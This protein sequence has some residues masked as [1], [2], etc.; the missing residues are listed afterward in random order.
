MA[1]I[2]DSNTA[3]QALADYLGITYA[4]AKDEVVGGKVVFTLPISDPDI[5]V[6]V[7][8]DLGVAKSDANTNRTVVQKS[9]YRAL[10]AT[11]KYILHTVTAGKTLYVT[12]LI[13]SISQQD[14]VRVGDNVSTNFT[15]LIETDNAVT[16]FLL[17][18]TAALVID[19]PVPMKISTD[20]SYATASATSAGITMIGWEE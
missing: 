4:E 13:I 1:N 11:T 16:A 14:A 9:A 17:A 18:G 6:A 2:L 5:A 3:M 19:F 15:P 20:L 7:S 12:T 10:S 8:G